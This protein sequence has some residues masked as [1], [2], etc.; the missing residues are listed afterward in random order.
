MNGP[1]EI[2]ALL[3]G[4]DSKFLWEKSRCLYYLLVFIQRPLN[5]IQPLL[6]GCPQEINVMLPYKI[7]GYAS[8]LFE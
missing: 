6:K 8:K 1:H 7:I 2:L 3:I 5:I 4:T